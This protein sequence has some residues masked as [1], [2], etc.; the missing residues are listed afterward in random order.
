MVAKGKN[1]S[2]SHGNSSLS[3]DRPEIQLTRTIL[4]NCKVTT[5][6][7]QRIFNKVRQQKENG[8]FIPIYIF[9]RRNPIRLLW[10]ND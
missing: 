3:T 1:L 10:L 7:V 4:T 2:F 8:K 6:I 5:E 9:D